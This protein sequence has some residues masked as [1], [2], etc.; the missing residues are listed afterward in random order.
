[1]RHLKAILILILVFSAAVMGDSR[2]RY[3]P[4][5]GGIDLTNAV[6]VNPSDDIA[7]KYDWLKSSARD[8]TMGA[9]SHT[10]RRVLILS[11]GLYDLASTLTLDASYIDITSLTPLN[12]EATVLFSSTAAVTV[13]EQT[14]WDIRLSGFTIK[15]ST[16]GSM[17][18]N[19]GSGLDINIPQITGATTS[20]MSGD[21]WLVRKEGTDWAVNLEL[22]E[23]VYLTGTNITSGW[24]PI[25]WNFTNTIRGI[26]EDQS[27]LAMYAP[28]GIGVANGDATVDVG[29]KHNLYNWMRFP[30]ADSG[31]AGTVCGIS[32]IHGVWKDCDAGRFAWRV[33]DDGHVRG[34]FWRCIAGDSSFG[35]DG[36]DGGSGGLPVL[37]GK[38]YYCI[39]GDGS[40][41]GCA[42][43]AG[44]C[45][46]D[47]YFY[48][49]EAGDQSFAM[50]NEFAGT[51]IRCK[52]GIDSFAGTLSGGLNHADNKFTGFAQGCSSEGGRSFGAGNGD[53]ST[54]T[55]IDCRYGTD[56][57]WKAGTLSV[58]TT[59]EDWAGVAKNSHPLIP[60][61]Y[62]GNK[63]LRGI[64]SGHVYNNTGAGGAI[65][66]TLPPA[67]V[68]MKFTILR[69]DIA[70]GSD[71]TVDPDAADDITLIDGTT[72][73]TNGFYRTNTSDA[74]GKMT[75]ECFEDTHWVITEEV[76]TWASET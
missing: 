18:P 22:D 40:F 72:V 42:A 64:E 41:S 52:A 30:S 14:T 9:A 70:A 74:F 21:Y 6:T 26:W 23:E 71:V 66:L 33:M 32:P 58:D 28:T 53:L 47:S 61:T 5:T 56:A 43:F 12:P 36:D 7:A 73:L 60:T 55:L 27:G 39:A 45:D 75:V 8:G 16:G 1:M 11:P 51:A 10:N 20:N 3:E 67:L 69:I 4:G 76:G 34:E 44:S 50:K 19:V 46:S 65:T 68:G 59:G 57:N 37:S 25:D 49:C 29:I 2:G 31:S 35:G 17:N 63:N 13:V 62:T 54:G 15:A 38:F 24:Y 48:E